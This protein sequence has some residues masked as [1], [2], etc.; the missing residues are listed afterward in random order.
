MSESQKVKRLQLAQEIVARAQKAGA[1][2]AEAIIKDGSELSVKVRKGETELVE[3]AA[4]M[5]VGLRVIIDQ[6]AAVT[7]T[8]DTT[9]AG[10]EALVTD[11]IEVAQLSQADEFNTP[12]DPSLLAT[13]FADLDLCDTSAQ[14]LD[15]SEAIRRA[16]EGE[17]A[18]E[19]YDDRIT[20]S[21]GANF[22]RNLGGMA[23][24]TSGGFSGSYDSSFYSMVV[25]PIAEVEGEKM[26]VGYHWDAKRYIAD[27]ASPQSIGQEAARRTLAKLGAQKVDTCEAAV[28]FDPDTGRALLSALFQCLAGSAIYRRASYLLDQEGETIANDIVNIVDDPL[29]ERAPGSRPFDGEG[30]VSRK[31]IV[32][33]KGVLKTY[34]LDTYSARKLGKES[35]GNASRG[36]SGS[37]S[38]APTNFQLLPT[39]QTPEDI[40][41]S[42][43]SGLYVTN[44]MGFGFNPVTGDFSRGAEGFWIENGEKTKPVG[45]ITISLNFKDLWKRIDAIGNDLIMRTAIATPTFRVSQ[46]T[47]A[48]S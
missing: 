39:E 28:I 42:T 27:L 6:R 3:E 29:I 48:G 5:G 30:L 45:E 36:I 40:I 17:K 18:A 13:E 19:T 1:P 37:P 9:D 34:L 16:I 24:V 43:S 41:K 2:V 44:M 31:N 14:D 35:T 4:P 10:L 32:V 7:Y 47:I 26:Q 15:A 38:V 11:A 33:E 21:E 46:M 23:L 20:N 12:P 22:G 25:S 8:N